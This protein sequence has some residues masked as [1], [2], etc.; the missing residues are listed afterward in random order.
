MMMILTL[1]RG[2]AV[3]EDETAS[4]DGA[5]LSEDSDDRANPAPQDDPIGLKKTKTLRFGMILTPWT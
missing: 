5:H 3:S 1:S 2:A 4:G